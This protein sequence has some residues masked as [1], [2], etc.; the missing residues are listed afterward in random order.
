MT[1]TFAWKPFDHYVYN[2]KHEFVCVISVTYIYRMDE[3]SSFFTRLFSYVRVLI[4][5]HQKYN[6]AATRQPY[7]KENLHSKTKTKSYTSF[8]LRWYWNTSSTFRFR[9]PYT[10]ILRVPV[11]IFF[12]FYHSEI[13]FFSEMACN[14]TTPVKKRID[15]LN[16][17]RIFFHILIHTKKTSSSV[18][19]PIKL[20]AGTK[21]D[22]SFFYARRRLTF[23][24][25]MR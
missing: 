11:R 10:L 5:S 13:L 8:D 4:K 23:R 15:I 25:G 1:H 9:N 21:K 17:K 3:V 7:N 12:L 14:Y 6:V 2:R 24:L 19:L 18:F 22:R 20:P 16:K